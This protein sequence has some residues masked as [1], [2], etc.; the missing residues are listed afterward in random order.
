VRPVPRERWVRRPGADG[1]VARRDDHGPEPLKVP[2]RSAPGRAR[3]CAV[4]CPRA[5]PTAQRRN[6]T[7]R[8]TFSSR[9]RRHPATVRPAGTHGGRR[10]V[11]PK[12][13]SSDLAAHQPAQFPGVV[14]FRGRSWSARR[15]R[16]RM[17]WKRARSYRLAGSGPH[18]PGWTEPNG[19]GQPVRTTRRRPG[20]QSLPE[21]RSRRHGGRACP[22][23]GDVAVSSAA[24]GAGGRGTRRYT[25][26]PARR[27]GGARA[28][29]PQKGP[30]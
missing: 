18:R 12:S 2:S 15:Q 4:G 11:V 6:R 28:R 19:T 16:E 23:C 22:L 30:A 3:R 5:P 24:T 25:H 9:L 8:F 7:G 29:G 10:D 17:T 20:I 27:V 1:S 14:A 13:W 21:Q 26:P